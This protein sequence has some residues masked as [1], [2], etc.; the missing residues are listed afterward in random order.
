MYPIF[1]LHKGQRDLHAYLRWLEAVCINALDSLGQKSHRHQKEDTN[2]T[3]VWV[4]DSNNQALKV[5]SI[6]VAVSRWVTYHGLA[7]NVNCD[8]SPNQLIHPC[9]FGA[10]VMT[11]VS[12]AGA[13]G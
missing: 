3:G 1:K 6:G 8:L 5:A 4:T 12:L 11:T 9:G 10:E 7:L 13:F 2:T